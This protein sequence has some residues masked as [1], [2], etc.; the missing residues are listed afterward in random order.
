MAT[1]LAD[2][3]V[4]RTIVVVDEI[5]KGATGKL[6]RI[7][8][9][10]RLGLT[11]KEP[12][13]EVAFAPPRTALEEGLAGIWAAVLDIPSVGIDDD[14]F[15]LGGDSILGAEA[16]AR[17]GERYST[18]LPLSTLLWAPTVAALALVVEGEE[19]DRDALL[20]PVQTQGSQ[21]PLFVTHALGNEV[22]N[23]SVLK[24]T[25]GTD[26]PL[27]AVRARLDRFDYRNV[28]ELAADYVDEIRSL[29]ASGPYCFASVCS[30][31]SIV[32][33]MARRVLSLG[34]SV[35]VVAVIDPLPA[36]R[37]MA[38]YYANRVALH[39]RNLRLGEATRDWMG[40]SFAKATP[41][42][43]SAPDSG[44]FTRSAERIRDD[45]RLKRLPTTLSVFS[46]MDY[47]TQR[48]YWA[49]FAARLDWYDLPVPHVTMFH[50]PHAEL[51][52]EAL[53]DALDR[54]RAE[55]RGRGPAPCLTVNEVLRRSTDYL[56]G[57]GVPSP[58][59]DAEHL[60]ASALGLSRLELYTQF[61]RPLSESELAAV[62]SLL[63]RRGRREPLAY[64]L[65][66]WGFRR[67]TLKIDRRALIPRPETEVV[68]ER[69]LALLGE[70]DEANVLDIGTGS[71]AIALAVVD[72][73]PGAHVTA[74]DISEDAL[75]LARENAEL[76]ELAARVT[77]VR[78]DLAAGLPDG[79]YDLIVSN[80]P[81]VEP[82]EIDSLEPEVREWEPRQALVGRGLTEAIADG[83]RL[84]LR[85]GGWLVLEVADGQAVA[86]S[87]LMAS[88]GFGGI[89]RT[90]DLT[91]RERVVEGRW[92]S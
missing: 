20:V 37:P 9:A 63:E 72:E 56:Q 92:E 61:D 39:R 2:F 6:Q 51:L 14:F 26:Q 13:Q 60:L 67:L 11:D 19:W 55:T 18:D 57:K 41:S 87:E 28:E 16:L 29:Q 59:V 73:H 22:F 49:P 46:T 54:S 36:R 45:Y 79:L 7:G 88:L 69:C 38:R 21:P 64:V 10:E 17:V 71:G 85:P 31:V 83:A 1:R 80:P 35:G 75:E 33:E 8:L 77:F 25:L 32:I 50:Q 48:G 12:P 53:R 68:V 86:V 74:I 52:G 82:E 42:G 58:R 15:A 70:T 62:R 4:P 27:Y 43:T 84:V 30:G 91:E 5:P 65:G 24:E 3:K 47:E 78:H 44:D 76:A 81:Y 23:V 66:E 90:A 89:R 40:R 34:E